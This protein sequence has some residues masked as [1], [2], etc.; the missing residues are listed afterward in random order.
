VVVCLEAAAAAS[1]N[2]CRSLR[3]SFA[4]RT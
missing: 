3:N 2:A 1:S 4:W